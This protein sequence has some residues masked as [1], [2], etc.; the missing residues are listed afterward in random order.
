MQVSCPVPLES[1]WS[2]VGYQVVEVAVEQ[3]DRILAAKTNGRTPRPL[4]RSPLGY[5]VSLVAEEEPVLAAP[6]TRTSV[7]PVKRSS[8]R[9]R[10][11][12]MLWVAIA[13]GVFCIVPVIGLLVMMAA[14]ASARRR[15]LVHLPVAPA[16]VAQAPQVVLPEPAQLVNVQEEPAPEDENVVAEGAEPAEKVGAAVALPE[17]ETFGT[18]VS[19]VRNP[20]EAARLARAENKL[21]FLLHVSGNFEESRFT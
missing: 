14:P 10:D 9:Q 8:P 18:T 5:R 4:P 6:R 19:F 1:P 20:A 2:P 13:V 12:A 3:P 21:T 17:C 16:N 15:E 7:R 11:P